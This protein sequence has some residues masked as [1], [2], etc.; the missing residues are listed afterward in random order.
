MLARTTDSLTT[1]CRSCGAYGGSQHAFTCQPGRTYKLGRSR[2]AARDRR[3]SALVL[4]N[5]R[6][7]AELIRNL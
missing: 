1:P 5:Q 4:E 3:L 6:I 7:Q 2:R